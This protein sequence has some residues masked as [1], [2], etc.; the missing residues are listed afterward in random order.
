MFDFHFYH[1]DNIDNLEDH[2]QNHL[3]NIDNIEQILDHLENVLKQREPCSL[4]SSCAPRGGAPG[5][6]VMVSDQR[7][8]SGFQ[9]F[10]ELFR[11]SLSTV[12]TTVVG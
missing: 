3:E 6:L 2:P 8:F 7:D 4:L 5:L 1:L 10:S 12:L 9:I 11:F